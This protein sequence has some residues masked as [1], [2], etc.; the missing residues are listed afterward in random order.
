METTSTAS[1]L[2]HAT[3]GIRV[4]HPY[5]DDAELHTDEIVVGELPLTEHQSMQFQYDFGAGWQFH[6]R[7]EKIEPEAAEMGGAV[8]VESHGEAPPEYEFVGEW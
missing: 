6:V 3:A 1:N 2:S 5:I 8:I 4:D 7:L